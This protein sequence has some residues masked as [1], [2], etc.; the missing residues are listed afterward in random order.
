MDDDLLGKILRTVFSVAGWAALCGV[1]VHW[2]KSRNERLRDTA[3]EKAGDWVRI[4]DERDHALE[5]AAKLRAMLAECERI[6][7]ERLGRAVIA[8]AELIGLNKLLEQTTV[9]PG[10][11]GMPHAGDESGAE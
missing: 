10:A 4:R 6:S 5:E 2:W 7:I 9:L 3:A 1:I 11:E 8:E